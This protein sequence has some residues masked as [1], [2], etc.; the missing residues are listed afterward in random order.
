M[1]QSNPY[2]LRIDQELMEQLKLVANENA[3]SVNKEIEVAIRKHV[4]NELANL[5]TPVPQ[6]N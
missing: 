5:E 4:K 3:R 2:P 1:K 6:E